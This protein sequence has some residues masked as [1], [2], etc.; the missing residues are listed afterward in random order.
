[1]CALQALPAMKTALGYKIIVILEQYLLFI[2]AVVL[3][4]P[5]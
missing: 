3:D 5:D 4:N 1:M 2:C